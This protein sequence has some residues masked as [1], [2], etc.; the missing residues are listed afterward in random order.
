MVLQ[1]N[2]E[3]KGKSRP[4]SYFVQ[5]CTI[6]YDL[7]EEVY[8]VTVEDDHGK[9]HAKVS[10]KKEA[11]DLA[12]TVSNQQVARI[13]TST[14]ATYRVHALIEVNP[15]SKEMVENIRKWLSRPMP[16]KGGVE[17][18][19]NFFGSFVG[20]FVDRRIGQADKSVS[21]VSQWFELGKP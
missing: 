16:G 19:T 2:L 14:H 21:F 9:R 13:D 6:V 17:Q 7:W 15:V 3:E 20:I 5:T 12:T 18:Q 11:V 1:V 8:L 10:T 4:I